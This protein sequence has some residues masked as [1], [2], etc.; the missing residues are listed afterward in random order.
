MAA[1]N[2]S[3][4]LRASD[5]LIHPQAINFHHYFLQMEWRR[6]LRTA[7]LSVFNMTVVTVAHTAS[8][9]P[10]ARWRVSCGYELPA[11]LSVAWQL[12]V[13]VLILEVGFYYM[14][15]FVRCIVYQRLRMALMIT[16]QHL[17]SVS[18]R[19]VEVQSQC[20]QLQS[21]NQLNPPAYGPDHY[22]YC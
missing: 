7:G 11:P 2:L 15:R 3:E 8:L 13:C 9:W 20:M 16:S 22:S 1:L 19:S 12:V 17:F 21:C 14:H 4:V 6:Y 10:I 18:E 5:T